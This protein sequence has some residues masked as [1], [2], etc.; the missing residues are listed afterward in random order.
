MNKGVL[1]ERTIIEQ[2]LI[3]AFTQID[4]NRKEKEQLFDS[5]P[6]DLIIAYLQFLKVNDLKKYQILEARYLHQLS[7]SKI[8]LQL[9]M[10]ERV[11]WRKLKETLNALHKALTFSGHAIKKA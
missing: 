1:P 11:V 4:R 2:S 3:K 5:Q 8:A 10:T 7:G 9:H 6:Q